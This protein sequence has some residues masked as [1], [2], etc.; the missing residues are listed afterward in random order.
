MVRFAWT[1]WWLVLLL[2]VGPP[3]EAQEAQSPPRAAPQAVDTPSVELRDNYPNP[4]YA[5]TTIPFTIRPEVCREGH[6]P[7]VTLEIYN[8]LAQVVAV[9]L[10]AE[11][12]PRRLQ[13]LKLPCGDYE[14][15]WDGKLLDGSDATTGIYWYHLT[16]DRRRQANNMI[17][18]RR[19]TSSR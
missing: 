12:T 14:A 6:Q 2:A 16:V 9:P 4:F 15:I 19:V 17:L 11:Q 8:V 10:L 3:V 18:Q 5:S 13:R 1:G 7:T